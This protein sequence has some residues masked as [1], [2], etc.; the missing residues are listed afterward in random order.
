[1]RLRG[2]NIDAHKHKDTLELFKI[3]PADNFKSF[4]P[5]KED[6]NL[7]IGRILD[8]VKNPLKKTTPYHYYKNPITYKEYEELLNSGGFKDGVN[9]ADEIQEYLE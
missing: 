7:S 6:I 3:I 2:F 8:R 9:S 4:V 1:M 5:S